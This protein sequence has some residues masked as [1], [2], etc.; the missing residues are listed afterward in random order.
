MEVIGQLLEVGSLLALCFPG[1]KLGRIPSRGKR[2][3]D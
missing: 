1:L 2:F 3:E